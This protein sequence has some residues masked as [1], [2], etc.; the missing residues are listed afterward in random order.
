MELY[1]SL[2]P[3]F[4][5]GIWNAWIFMVFLLIQN[6]TVMLSKKLYRRLG[7]P[8]SPSQGLADRVL[9]IF[10]TTLWLL[11]SAYSIFLP[12]KLG[13]IW[14]VVGLCLFTLAMAVMITAIVNFASTPDNVPVTKGVY[15]YSRHPLYLAM[16]FIY[17]SVGFASASWIFL[18][19]M[20][21]L[22][23]LF[24][25]SAKGEELYCLEKY[26]QGYRVYT[27]ITPRWIG[28]PNKSI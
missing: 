19:V 3:A 25:L 12:F 26:G 10:A 18:L 21:F 24:A 4:E 13:T 16:L 11:S 8:S 23:I 6:L 5:I 22:A 28:L 17:V 7:E 9:N 1:V 20:V 15:R 27:S 2:V 14:F